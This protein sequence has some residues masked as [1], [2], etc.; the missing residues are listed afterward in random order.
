MGGMKDFAKL[1]VQQ[2][3]TAKTV[4]T[5]KQVAPKITDEIASLRN[6]IAIKNAKKAQALTDE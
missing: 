5:A 4:A 1:V 2:T 3:A 6:N